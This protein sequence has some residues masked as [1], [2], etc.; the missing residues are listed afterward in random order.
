MLPMESSQLRRI[1]GITIL[2]PDFFATDQD[3]KPLSPIAVIFPK[4]LLLVTGRGIHAEL[5]VMGGE[6]LRAWLLK[7]E[8]R[9]PTAEE[10]EEIYENVVSLLVRDP[11]VLIR[12]YPDDMER[13]FAA[14]ELLQR[15]LP[16]ERIQFTGVHIAEVREQLRR[17][18]ENWRFSPP[19]RSAKEICHHIHASRVQVK[20]GTTYYQNAQSGERFLT[21]EEFIRIRPLLRQAPG[22]AL[23]RLKEIDYLSRLVNDQE[24]PELSFFIPTKKRLAT[25]LLEDLTLALENADSRQDLEQAED[26]FDHFAMSFAGAAGDELTV[27][28]EKHTTWQTTMFCRLYDLDE[29][30][31]EERTLGLS[32]E[33]HLNVRWLPG[34]QLGEN[35]VT[36]EAKSEPRVRSLITYFLQT[37]PGIVSINIGR[38]ESSLTERDRTGEEREVFLVV[39]GLAQG[40]EEIR[41]LRLMKWDVIHRLKQGFPLSQAISDTIRYRDYVVDRLR[42]TTALEIPILSYSAIEFAEE[43]QG[44]GQIPVFFFDR[45]YVAGMVSDKIPL[46]YFAKKGFVVRLARLLGAAAAASMV[47]G[48][49]SYR[50]GDLFFD[51]GDEVIQLNGE[52]LPERLIISETTGSFTNS[53][54]PISELL[55]Q[56]LSHLAVHLKKARDR[57]I[58]R[59]DLKTAVAVFAEAL[60]TEIE[61]MQSLLSD[62][63]VALQSLFDGQTSEPGSLRERWK[64]MMDR[65]AATDT[66]EVQRDVLSSPHLAEF[67]S[68]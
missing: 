32:P 5:V 11:I 22:E 62:Q 19:P 59:E 39:L 20:T 66:G 49:A 60:R 14:D 36:F 58:S 65:L 9:D 34:A 48:R 31:V 24:A 2:G 35:E 17:R 54:T 7:T 46:H 13:V 16:K 40:G 8:E 55:P 27:D 6:V 45:R 33:F 56:C 42:A 61:R 29:E 15:L 10:E 25:N 23:A 4:L 38:V 63:S 37:W 43:I 18:G 53:T 28:G 68:P 67:M 30:L 1:E 44:I 64:S 51:D 57:G 26:F 47:L 3:C 21:Y 12:S 50:R 52:K 41:L